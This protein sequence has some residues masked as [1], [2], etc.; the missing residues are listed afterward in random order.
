MTSCNWG[1]S[2]DVCNLFFPKRALFAESGFF[3][4]G[5]QV[6]ALQQ[7]HRDCSFDA[8]ENQALKKLPAG[9]GIQNVRDSRACDSCS[10]GR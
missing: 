6:K 10:K 1:T 5:G 8:G 3:G 7:I 2:C 4:D 9:F